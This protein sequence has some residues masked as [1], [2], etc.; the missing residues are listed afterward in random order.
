MYKVKS[1]RKLCITVSAFPKLKKKKKNGFAYMYPQLMAKVYFAKRIQLPSARVVCFEFPKGLA[2]L[3]MIFFTSRP[4]KTRKNL[5]NEG[6]PLS[7]VYET[8]EIGRVPSISTMLLSAG[9]LITEDLIAVVWL[10]CGPPRNLPLQ[11]STVFSTRP[12]N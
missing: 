6:A 8:F 4:K 1:T 10:R 3:R 2:S 12:T 7:S 5:A 11:N 9:F